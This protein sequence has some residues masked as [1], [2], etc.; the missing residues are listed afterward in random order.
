MTTTQ[1][2]PNYAKEFRE[3]WRQR[4][5]NRPPRGPMPVT[6][7]GER[8]IA[9]SMAKLCEERGFPGLAESHRLHAN[10]DPSDCPCAACEM[11]RQE[12]EEAR[13]RKARRQRQA[14]GVGH[15]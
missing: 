1:D 13:Q 11:T 5:A 12:T 6:D 4:D 2:R 9:I 7:E 14:Q 3:A 10:D 15:A 8:R